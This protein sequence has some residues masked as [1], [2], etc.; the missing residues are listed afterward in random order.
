MGSDQRKRHAYHALDYF[1]VNLFTKEQLSQEPRLFF[2][3]PFEG[4]L[5]D[6]NERAA[7]NRIPM[8]S[9]GLCLY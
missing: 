6:E 8:K 1:F 4:I 3:I 9:P 5:Y 7:M 2:S